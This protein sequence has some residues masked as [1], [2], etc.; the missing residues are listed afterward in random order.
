M[1]NHAIWSLKQVVSTGSSEAIPFLLQLGSDFVV[2]YT[3]PE[4]DSELEKFGG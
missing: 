1:L 2:D 3:S 4:A